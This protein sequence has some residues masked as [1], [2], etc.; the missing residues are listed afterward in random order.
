MTQPASLSRPDAMKLLL[1][2][3][4][5]DLA[6]YHDM[7]ALMELQFEAAIRHQGERLMEIA[8]VI[9]EQC[10]GM[11]ARRSQRV[12]LASQLVGEAG[13]MTAV[14]ALLKPAPRAQLMADWQQLE[15]M[16]QAARQ[17]G[18]RNA[19]LLAEQYSIMQRVLH[20]EDQTYAPA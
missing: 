20:G 13:A 6:A 10:D 2:G 19:E 11:E 18:K 8:A 16:V 4:A 14:A 5:D 9:S 7:L 17:L 15:A 1:Q 3:V 12:A